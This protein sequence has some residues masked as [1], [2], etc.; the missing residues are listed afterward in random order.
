M[1][2]LTLLGVLAA[3][4]VSAV[5]S[6]AGVAWVSERVTFRAS[7]V[8][9]SSVFSFGAA[10]TRGVFTAPISTQQWAPHGSGYGGT[11]VADTAVYCR[12][13]ISPTN[14]SG[15]AP[16]PSSNDTLYVTPQVSDDGNNW[17]NF[18]NPS[19]VFV[20]SDAQTAGM[21]PAY[22]LNGCGG[23]K[24]YFLCLR[25]VL[26]ATNFP[27]QVAANRSASTAPIAV[28]PVG[29]PFL[30]FSI[31]GAAAQTGQYAARIYHWQV[32][33]AEAVPV[34]AEIAFRSQSTSFFQGFADSSSFSTGA[35]RNDTTAA[36]SIDGWVPF[37]AMAMNLADTQGSSDTTGF[38][39]LRIFQ[40]P[41]S[42][43]SPNTSNVDT[44]YVQ[45]QVSMNGQD[46]MTV[47]NG[48]TNMLLTT[49]VNNSGS[50]EWGFGAQTGNSNALC[51]PSTSNQAGAATA[52]LVSRTR[53]FGFPLVRFIVLN[54][55]RAVGQYSARLDGFKV[56][57]Q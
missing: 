28:S 43:L 35:T 16:G 13:E 25:T 38:I 5:P 11:T 55:G 47:T 33:A 29:W 39:R 40:T 57:L 10:A 45:T 44:M 3:L 52:F 14:S 21:G 23:T 2:R 12:L 56:P 17:V 15:Q 41:G 50:Y 46:W 18:G 31:S 30:R 51:Y 37:P 9:D 27:L 32:S 4:F 22:V 8:P 53:M 6:Q 24:S 19:R 54:T 48:T 1:R 49:E 7:G 34:R 20:A 26:S 42:T 36:V